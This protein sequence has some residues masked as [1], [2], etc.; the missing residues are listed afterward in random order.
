MVINAGG[1][2]F[3]DL[4]VTLNRS[5][6]PMKSF[7]GQAFYLCTCF[8]TVWSFWSSYSTTCFGRLVKDSAAP[9]VSIAPYSILTVAASRLLKKR[10]ER[11]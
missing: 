7:S 6:I 3:I 9:T 8:Y 10:P 2:R 5:N 11:T 1:A 4:K